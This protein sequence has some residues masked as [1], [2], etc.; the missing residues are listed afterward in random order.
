MKNAADETHIMKVGQPTQDFSWSV[1]GTPFQDLLKIMPHIAMTNNHPSGIACRSGCVLQKGNVTLTGR[2]AYCLQ[3]L[4]LC[5]DTCPVEPN[6][7][8]VLIA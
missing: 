2:L 3:I 6:E 7:V 8:V 5:F 4:C 1:T